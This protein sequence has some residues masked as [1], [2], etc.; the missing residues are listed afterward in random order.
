[1][2]ECVRG[3]VRKR[4]NCRCVLL[5]SEPARNQLKVVFESEI[6][7]FLKY[8]LL[9]SPHTPHGHLDPDHHV[10]HQVPVVV[11]EK[12]HFA[13][14]VFNPFV[15]IVSHL[16]LVFFELLLHLLHLLSQSCEYTFRG[17]QYSLNLFF[18][19]IQ[20]LL[21]GFYFVGR[22]EG[23][24]LRSTLAKL[25]RI[26]SRIV[27]LAVL[28]SCHSVFRIHIFKLLGAKI[29]SHILAVGRQVCVT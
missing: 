13:L 9:K 7:G 12:Y 10:Q 25:L 28:F 16:L 17:V 8:H 21:Q 24:V 27:V 20:P 11:S 6:F 4:V 19:E 14:A 5:V 1:M 3:I 23:L 29:G 22:L 2:V 18:D 26:A 15:D